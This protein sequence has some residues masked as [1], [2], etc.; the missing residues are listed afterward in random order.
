MDL[1]WNTLF[2]VQWR[3]QIGTR[4][5]QLNELSGLR[6]PIFLLGATSVDT[7]DKDS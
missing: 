7:Q 1:A 6:T 2:L 4:G 5:N 3:K